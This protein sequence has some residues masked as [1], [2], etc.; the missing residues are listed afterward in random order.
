MDAETSYLMPTY[1]RL[2]VS[3]SRGEGAR[4]WDTEGV[5]YLDALAGIAVATLG[6]AHPELAAVI[7]DQARLLIHTSNLYRIPAQEQLGERLCRIAGMEQAFFTN[8]GAE[9][10]EAAIKIARR[11]GHDNGI[12]APAILV[13]DGAFHGRTMAT[14]T[15]SGSRKVQAGFEPLVAG[16]RRVPFDDLDAVHQ[17]ARHAPD[18]VAVLVEPIQGEGGIR[19]PAPDYLPGLAAICRE[20]GW[21]LMLDEIQTGMGRSGRWFEYQHHAITP[22]VVTVAKALGNGFPIGA[23]LARGPAAGVLGAGSHGSTFGGNPL[24]CRVALTVIDIL[25]RSGALDNAA[26][27][28]GRIMEGLRSRLEGRP[29]VAAIR[30]RG[31]MLGV[32]MA[33]PCKELMG[34]ALENRILV[35]VTADS[36]VRLL[37]P[38]IYADTDSDELVSALVAT[39]EQGGGQ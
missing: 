27:Q 29:E 5:C 35:N 9:A 8:S 20:Q 12:E 34:L 37:P 36:V 7:A 6:H 11:H 30:G 28:G 3:F 25:E 15:A 32:E 26:R 1:G 4:L 19:M 17:A 10:N 39:I 23:C 18:V 13:T 24:A 21:L 2:P 31:L 16:F 33:R 38:L 14:L 22:D